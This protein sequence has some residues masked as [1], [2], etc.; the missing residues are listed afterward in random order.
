MRKHYDDSSLYSVGDGS[1]SCARKWSIKIDN[2]N[3]AF[4]AVLLGDLGRD[5]PKGEWNHWLSY[6]IPPTQKMS[7]TGFLRSVLC[8][9]VESSSPE[10]HFKTAYQEVN[11]V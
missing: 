9:F 4:I 11:R 10:Y 2:G 3:P 5:I 6:N 8:Q 7:E 1:L